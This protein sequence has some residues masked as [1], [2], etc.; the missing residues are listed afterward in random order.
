[1]MAGMWLSKHMTLS[2][3]AGL[4]MK[5]TS[6]QLHSDSSVHRVLICLF[7]H[8]VSGR[9]LARCTW[10]WCQWQKCCEINYNYSSIHNSNHEQ[11]GTFHIVTDHLF[12]SKLLLFVVLC[13]SS[14]SL[15]LA[16]VMC[17]V[18]QL[19][20]REFDPNVVCCSIFSQQQNCTWSLNNTNLL[21]YNE[22]PHWPY[23]IVSF[24]INTL[25]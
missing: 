16:G 11:N 24:M 10:L 12:D 25:F 8:S 20:Q 14:E 18:S 15:P 4:N 6:G 13:K 3:C 9:T 19:L 7:K 5:L 1:M 17:C 2:H 22:T 23:Y 21:H